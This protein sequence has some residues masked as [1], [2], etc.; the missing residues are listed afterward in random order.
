[1]LSEKFV[2]VGFVFVLYLVIFA[3]THFTRNKTLI[4]VHTPMTTS[5]H[6]VTTVLN[7][8]A[9]Q[10]VLQKTFVD[11]KNDNLAVIVL[12]ARNSKERRNV[13]RE[14][15]GSGHSNVYFM[16]GKH[17]PY[18]PDQRKPCV[19]EPKHSNVLIDSDYIAQQETL[20]R[21]LGEEPNVIMVDMIDVYRNLA[22]KLFKSYQ[23]ILENTSARYILKMDDDSFARVSSVQHWLEK[24]K[25]PP[26]FEIIAATF[27][28]GRPSR[29][30][31]WAET[32]Y[33]EDTYPPWPSGAGHIVSRPVLEYM[34]KHP[35]TWVSYQGEDTSMGIWME[36]VRPQIDVQ[37]TESE[38]FITHSGDCH[39]TNKFVIGHDIS[40]E[41]MRE[42]YDTMDEYVVKV[43]ANDI[44]TRQNNSWAP[45]SEQETLRLNVDSKS[46]VLDRCSNKLSGPK[47]DTFASMVR[48]LNTLNANYSI[49]HG[50]VLFWYRDC[51]LG[52]SDI[53]MD[54]EFGWFMENK[55]R[56]HEALLSS[57][58]AHMYSFGKHDQFG[59]EESWKKNGIKTDLFSIAYVDGRYINGM[60]VRGVTHPCDSFLE[61]YVVHTWNGISF[62]VPEPI[63]P[64]LRG[65]YGDWKT[66]HVH[67]YQWDVEPFKTDNGRKFCS[68]TA[69]PLTIKKE[70]CL[71]LSLPGFKRNT[72]PTYD[73]DTPQRETKLYQYNVYNRAMTLANNH[74]KSWII[75]IGCGSGKKLA[76]MH[77]MGFKVVGIDFGANI[78]TT[79]QKQLPS[80]S[81][82]LISCDLNKNI[83]EISEEILRNCVF[84]SSDVIEHLINP[85]N[86]VKII[87]SYIGKGAL[88]V[89][90]TPDNDKLTGAMTPNRPSDVQ[91]WSKTG[92][93]TYLKCHKLDFM[94][95]ERI[96]NN[97][98]NE[99]NGVG[100]QFG[101]EVVA[102]EYFEDTTVIMKTVNRKDA[103]R[104]C[105]NS[106]RKFVRLPII[107]VDDGKVDMT[108]EFKDVTYIKI[109]FDSGLSEGRNVAV[110]H[111]RTRY[112]LVVDDDFLFT[113]DIPLT[114]LKNMLE[115]FD[116]VGGK[117]SD[118]GPYTA[119]MKYIDGVLHICEGLFNKYNDYCYKTNRVL[120]L[121]LARTA[122]LRNNPWDPKRK[123]QEHTWWFATLT[124][125][126]AKIVYCSNFKISHQPRKNTQAYMNMRS[127][128]F[129]FD[130][131]AIIKYDCKWHVKEVNPQNHA[132]PRHTTLVQGK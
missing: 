82:L 24:R 28:R 47:W 36:K 99:K 63:E 66:K 16:V 37:R 114:Y 76:Y 90:S 88:G 38:H 58:W 100:A 35:D 104:R 84:V 45:M 70:N 109:P 62:K 14:T 56:L 94:L 4:R 18:R 116:I 34:H 74:N 125:V 93:S 67:G 103:T 129:N 27:N 31:K 52:H 5:V 79:R 22:E 23:W 107:V 78:E 60:T 41:K 50:T 9:P 21:K 85:D 120:N 111:V 46:N 123:L 124:M 11:K 132:N 81:A 117:L 75:D 29:S 7:T 115:N 2:F 10:N 17:C 39:N 65:K 126:H 102:D 68:K 12:V 51:S 32:K 122:F 26:T 119:D 77:S 40:I 53:D 48:V 112:T 13:I 73:T 113:E 83:P 59:Y 101:S 55:E 57:G 131:D 110:S 1:M 121:F 105:I 86:L 118:R 19:C 80:D 44:E 69:M 15:W 6:N 87:K 130:D 127:R 91:V 49:S 92:F 96:N 71:K 33:K 106:L 20:T 43:T 108:E 98:D 61:R 128:T 42:C 95:F 72:H 30:G 89:I 54:I 3:R 25:S 8:V 97:I 64:Y